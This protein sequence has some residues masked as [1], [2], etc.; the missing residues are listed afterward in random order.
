MLTATLLDTQRVW[1]LTNA[2]IEPDW[3]IAEVPQLLARK[4]FDPH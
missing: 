4:H 2:A 1:G 3:V